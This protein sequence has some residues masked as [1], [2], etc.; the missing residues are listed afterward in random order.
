MFYLKHDHKYKLSEIE[1]PRNL[2]NVVYTAG[3]KSSIL[4][5]AEEIHIIYKL[6]VKQL[7]L[8]IDPICYVAAM[9]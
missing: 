8:H 1:L 6:L 9:D 7:K 2:S 5:A 3:S 4:G